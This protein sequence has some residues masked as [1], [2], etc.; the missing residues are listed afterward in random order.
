MAGTLVSIP[1]RLKLNKLRFD[2][3]ATEA[4]YLRTG[5]NTV[6]FSPSAQVYTLNLNNIVALSNNLAKF[7]TSGTPNFELIRI[8]GYSITWNPAMLVPVSGTF[9]PTAF[10]LRHFNYHASST[11]L[12]SGYQGNFNEVH[13][14][15]LLSQTNRPVRTVFS[16]PSLPLVLSEQAQPCIGQYING[17]TFVTYAPNIGGIISIMQ[18]IPALN[19]IPAYN[20]KLGF[21]G[22]KLHVELLNTVV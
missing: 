20:P 19:T 11:N 1:S 12:P 18:S 16:L 21:F 2:V 17:Y 22:F 3:E 9:E 10:Q 4:I 7:L 8:T 13:Y 6:S 5:Q 15:V 14:K